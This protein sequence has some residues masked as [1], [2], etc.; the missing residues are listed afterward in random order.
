MRVLFVAL[1]LLLAGCADEPAEPTDS[2]DGN[3][4]N[5]P[6]GTPGNG[7]VPPLPEPITIEVGL[8]GLYP[9]TIA[10]DPVRIEVPAGAEVTIRFTNSDQN[11]VMS[12]DWVLEGVD[13]A[14]TE[15]IGVGETAEV[16]F[17]APAPGE[18]AF[19][20]SVGDHRSNGM[21]G[22]FVVA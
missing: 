18:Y 1:I 19:Y 16:T 9:V 4:S 12:H 6:E 22:V 5:A 13:G 20:C 15:V 10:Y 7:T 14:G 21:E 11:P 3:G 8:T 2:P 17:I